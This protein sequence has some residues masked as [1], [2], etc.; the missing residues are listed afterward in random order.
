MV[1]L[2]RFV[3]V[4]RDLTVTGRLPTTGGISIKRMRPFASDPKFVVKIL[5]DSIDKKDFGQQPIGE[6]VGKQD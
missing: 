1:S 5:L 4:D 3:H 6:V 2:C